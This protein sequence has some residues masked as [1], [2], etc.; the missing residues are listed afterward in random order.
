[1]GMTALIARFCKDER[2]LTSIEYRLLAAVIGIGIIVATK[3]LGAKAASTFT[4]SSNG[5]K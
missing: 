1:M 4:N 3:A 5:M 2:G